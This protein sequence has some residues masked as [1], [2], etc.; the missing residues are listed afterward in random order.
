VS[1]PAGAHVT[2]ATVATDASLRADRTAGGSSP[3]TAGGRSGVH[4]GADAT[5]AIPTTV[6]AATS[7]TGIGVDLLPLADGTQVTV[8]VQ[9]D[10]QGAPS[11]KQLAAG[12]VVLVDAGVPERVAIFFDPVVLPAGPVWVVLQAA[13]GHAVVL[14]T[15]DA[16]SST[17]VVRTPGGEAVFPGIS[18]P[19]ALFTRSGAA[20]AA[21]ATALAVGASTL[22][23]D[24]GGT[25]DISAALA[26]LG[27]GEIA[28]GFSAAVA[29]TV[30]VHAPHIE[31][32]L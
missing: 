26:A 32:S 16:S 29:G 27:G 8:E 19:V 24:D 2:K 15:A 17:R 28:L 3:A 25:Y 11:G 31:Y 23:P 6:A 12:R 14:A 30:T 21:P 1:L 20:A 22:T 7:V 10:W 13:K 5:T 4:V 18:V 9:E